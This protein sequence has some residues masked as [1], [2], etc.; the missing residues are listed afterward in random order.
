MAA[1]LRAHFDDLAVDQLDPVTL[2]KNAEFAEPEVVVSGKPNRSTGPVGNSVDQFGPTSRDDA[3]VG[4]ACQLLL[5]EPVRLR[6]LNGH[7]SLPS[8]VT[9]VFDSRT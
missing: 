5:G 6:E 2:A 7:T 1:S 9:T 3:D 4:H 8:I